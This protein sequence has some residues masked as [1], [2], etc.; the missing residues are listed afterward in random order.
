MTALPADNLSL[1]DRGRLRPGALA[2]VVV[3]DPNTIQDHATFEK[4]HQLSTG[5]SFVIVNGKLAVKDGKATGAATGRVVRGRAWT[6]GSEGGCRL[7][8]SDWVWSR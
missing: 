7:S 3:F 4:S 6:G 5:V 8:A 2:D 1:K